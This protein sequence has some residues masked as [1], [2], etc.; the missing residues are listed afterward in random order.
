VLRVMRLWEQDRT[1]AGLRDPEAVGKLPAAEQ[2]E[3]QQF[4]AEVATLRRRA[5]GNNP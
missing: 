5:A 2:A 4:W 1:L 3:C